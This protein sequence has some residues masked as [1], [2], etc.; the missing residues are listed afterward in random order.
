MRSV[1]RDVVGFECVCEVGSQ[2]LRFFLR[3]NSK[4]VVL[5]AKRRNDSFVF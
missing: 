3:S 2:T 1:W 5:V 4:V